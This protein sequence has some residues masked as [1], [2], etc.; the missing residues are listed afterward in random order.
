MWSRVKE[1]FTPEYRKE[2][3]YRDF[4]LKSLTYFKLNNKSEDVEIIV[5]RLSDSNF[6]SNFKISLENI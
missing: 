5:K 4:L 1:V 2:I 6:V 3:L